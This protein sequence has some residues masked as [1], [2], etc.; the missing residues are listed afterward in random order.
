MDSASVIN[1]AR[2]RKP[3]G[4]GGK[5]GGNDGGNQGGEAGEWMW[6]NQEAEG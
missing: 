4:E 1:I 3:E 6:W 2:R 5:E